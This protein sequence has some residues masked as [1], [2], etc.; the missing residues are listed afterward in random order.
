MSHNLKN[1]YRSRLFNL[2]NRQT[3]RFIIKSDRTLRH[4]QVAALWGVQIL[5]YPI[6]LL[7]QATLSAGSQLLTAT[8]AG[9]PRLKTFTSSPPQ[10]PPLSADTPIQQVLKEI[11]IIPISHKQT[12]NLVPNQQ[13]NLLPVAYSLFP[14]P[15]G[16][17]IK[18]S[19]IAPELLRVDKSTFSDSLT[20]Q[21]RGKAEKNHPL[22]IQGVASLLTNRNL[23]LVT[24]ENQILDILT[25]QQQQKLTARISWEMAN[26]LRQQR[27]AS[28]CE[29]RGVKRRLSNLDRPPL[30]LPL[31]LFW[32][33]MAWIQTSRVA[34]AINL[35]DEYTLLPEAEVTG[36]EEDAQKISNTPHPT[37]HWLQALIDAAI[38]Y[39]FGKHS[40]NLPD[41]DA[42]HQPGI[43]DN[44]PKATSQLSGS[45]ANINWRRSKLIGDSLNHSPSLNSRSQPQTNTFP[46]TSLTPA[47]HLASADI[48]QP[49][50]WLTWE[51][52]FSHPATDNHQPKIRAFNPENSQ[53]L[54]LLPEGLNNKIPVIPGRTIWGVLKNYISTKQPSGQLA[55][56]WKQQPIR[57]SDRQTPLSLATPAP[58]QHLK[59]NKTQKLPSD[60][61]NLARSK[62]G[63][64]IISQPTSS[65]QNSHLQP[66]PN[67]IETKAIPT[68]YIKHPLEQILE[69]LDIA[70]LWLE[71]IIIKIW[72]WLHQSLPLR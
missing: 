11:K 25:A 19:D 68:G 38:D 34:I 55:L 44:S 65:K 66:A 70:M 52:L 24:V 36:R 61:A 3:R 13:S 20:L 57:I 10:Q 27:L 8:Q 5:L 22:L 35:F 2:I 56:S 54:P 1:R 53:D 9:L 12:T 21:D 42:Q 32:R 14:L 29:F 15:K 16:I 48:N 51:D 47:V 62:P 58:S 49:D 71:E 39:F 4:L 63:I 69:W 43:S 31:R 41:T 7:V 30:I 72:R 45:Q 6:Y 18:K 60:H 59:I 26:L 50:P 40:Q 37:P 46:P 33:V 17:D 28:Q 23:V 64:Q 67:W